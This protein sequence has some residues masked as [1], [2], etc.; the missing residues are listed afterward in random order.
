MK[1][2]VSHKNNWF[3]AYEI[4]HS[5]GSAGAVFEASLGNG[6]GAYISTQSDI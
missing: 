1:Y 5:V 2:N 6:C 3:K 4:N